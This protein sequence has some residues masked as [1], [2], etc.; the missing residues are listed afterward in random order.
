MSEEPRSFRIVLASSSP[1]RRA[2]LE[3]LGLPFESLPADID[4]TALASEAPEGLVE[5]LSH[6][7]AA[8]VAEGRPASLIIGSD[9]V[10]LHRSRVSGKPGTAERAAANLRA[11]SGE[12]V[13]FLTGVAVHGAAPAY[14]GYHCDR[15]VV[16]FRHLNDAEIDRYVRRDRPLDCAGSFRLEALGPALFDEVSSRDPTALLGLPLIGLCRLLREA[17][18]PLP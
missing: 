16:R 14:R 10:A 7:K 9:Q 18:C 12:E 8:A 17:G 6:A 11:F 1:A 3:R 2:L 13:V 5:R 4:E 15:T